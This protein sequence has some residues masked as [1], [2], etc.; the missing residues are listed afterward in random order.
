MK[1][2]KELQSEVADLKIQM[3]QLQRFYSQQP[4]NPIQTSQAGQQGAVSQRIPI[5]GSQFYIDSDGK[6][7]LRGVA[8]NIASPLSFL[9][10]LELFG[11]STG[12]QKG[13]RLNVGP[14]LASSGTFTRDKTVNAP[15]LVCDSGTLTDDGI[16]YM[17][18]DAT[19]APYAG[20]GFVSSQITGGL[21]GTPESALFRFDNS[22]ITLISNTANV[23]TTNTDNKLCLLHA[24]YS[25]GT[26]PTYVRMR[27][28]LG[29]TLIVGYILAYW[30][31]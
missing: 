22:G 4:L 30:A 27:Q 12:T 28:R 23:V 24:A 14:E 10:L 31:A 11:A 3:R 6:A 2:L 15:V 19:I 20:I 21:G 25:A 17:C 8:L 5:R 29:G 26:N 9:H 13:I 7:Y 16:L 1:T 18:Y